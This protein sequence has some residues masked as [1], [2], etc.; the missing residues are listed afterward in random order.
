MHKIANR[1]IHNPAESRNPA[2]ISA[3]AGTEFRYS[4]IERE[5]GGEGGNMMARGRDPPLLRF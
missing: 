1:K 2:K 3:E 4:S 5:Q